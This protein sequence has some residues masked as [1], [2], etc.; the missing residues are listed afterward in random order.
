MLL[1]DDRSHLP[2]VMAAQHA[3]HSDIMTIRVAMKRFVSSLKKCKY[4]LMKSEIT[5]PGLT[6]ITKVRLT[7]KS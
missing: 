7:Y 4:F 2:V 1:L 3:F 6:K 5:E